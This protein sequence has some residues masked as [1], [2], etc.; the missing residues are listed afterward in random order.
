MMMEVPQYAEIRTEWQAPQ[1]DEFGLDTEHGTLVEVSYEDAQA[2]MHIAQAEAGNQGID[3]M[4][5]VMQVVLN[6]VADEDY[7]DTVYDVI[8]QKGQFDSFR[9]GAYA[10][11]EPSAECHLALAEIEAGQFVNH[12]IIA[13]EVT[14]SRSLDRYFRYAFTYRDHDFYTEK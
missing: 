3:G 2:L 13:F 7:P 9:N 6:R 1:I 4:A 12:T 10:K 14:G 8:A 5:L 11:A